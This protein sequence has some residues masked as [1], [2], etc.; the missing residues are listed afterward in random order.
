MRYR[1]TQI[2]HLMIAALLGGLVLVAHVAAATHF[3]WTTVVGLVL[4][5][6][7]LATFATLTV[8]VTPEAVQV[9]LG[10]GL[11]RRRVRLSQIES[12]ALV[13]NAWYY[14]WGI[15]LI[16]RGWLW[17]VSGLRAVELRLRN[18]RRFAIGSDEPQSLA[19][20]IASHLVA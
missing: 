18:G 14:G 5:V 20:A 17:R 13:R 3:H 11:V 6:A 19:D 8:E 1:H 9:R 15:R 16:P 7:A 4:L 2:G 12:V 10:P